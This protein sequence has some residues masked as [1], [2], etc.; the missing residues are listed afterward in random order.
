[1][2]GQIRENI[3]NDITKQREHWRGHG[4]T[5]Y[6]EIMETMIIND[7]EFVNDDDDNDKSGR[8]N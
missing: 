2:T 7:R 5:E 4:D 3:E 6:S 1:M 8:K